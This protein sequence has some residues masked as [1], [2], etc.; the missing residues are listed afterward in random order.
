M[1]L[2]KDIFQNNSNHSNIKLKDLTL[3]CFDGEDIN[4][5]TSLF[6]KINTSKFNIN[7]FGFIKSKIEKSNLSNS[8]LEKC[9]LKDS[10]IIHSKTTGINFAEGKFLNIDFT[11]NKMDLSNFCFANLNNVTFNNCILSGSNFQG[12]ILKNIKFID[13]NLNNVDFSQ[14]RMNKVSL[15]GSK[16]VGVKIDIDNFKQ[17]TINPE[18]AV[19]I[20]GLLGINI[21]Y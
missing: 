7:S 13:C 20:A 11:N 10:S 18:Q 4:F 5:R 9:Y 1:K 8:K 14:A 19:Y 16:I 2:Y 3:E 17:L 6:I 12:T 15:K 21:E